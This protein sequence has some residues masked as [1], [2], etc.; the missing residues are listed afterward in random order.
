MSHS[1]SRWRGSMVWPWA[2]IVNARE[3]MIMRKSLSSFEAHGHGVCLQT[4]KQTRA[5][6]MNLDY[7]PWS[8]PWRQRGWRTPRG[9]KRERKHVL[10]G[11]WDRRKGTSRGVRT[12]GRQNTG[13]CPEFKGS[14]LHICE[15][16]QRW[17]EMKKRKPW[18][19]QCHQRFEGWRAVEKAHMDPPF[20][21]WRAERGT[22][23]QQLRVIWISH[24]LGDL[25]LFPNCKTSLVATSWWSTQQRK[26]LGSHVGN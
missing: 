7:Q 22:D 9:K 13:K 14:M 4:G 18:K 17:W 2:E 25:F 24:P 3:T 26:F 23:Q 19:R 16:A 12:G 6:G 21:K 5:R 10:W 11:I 15:A 8:G 1:E 20:K